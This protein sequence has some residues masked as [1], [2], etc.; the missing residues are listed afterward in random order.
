M[1]SNDLSASCDKVSPMGKKTDDFM[2]N[3]IKEQRKLRQI[4]TYTRVLLCTIL[5]S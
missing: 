1:G 4:Y 3:Y 5:Q 2:N